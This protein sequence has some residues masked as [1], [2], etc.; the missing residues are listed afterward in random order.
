[1]QDVS[2]WQRV[3]FLPLS[4]MYYKKNT[5]MIKI[6]LSICQT[7]KHMTI[8]KIGGIFFLKSKVRKINRP[9]FF[10]IFMEFFISLGQWS[11]EIYEHK[12]SLM[13]TMAKITE[14]YYR[15]F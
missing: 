3:S 5:I 14:Y 10:L 15:K 6:L 12:F 9:M 13:V 7:F 4:L 11:T 1:M 8:F 2:S